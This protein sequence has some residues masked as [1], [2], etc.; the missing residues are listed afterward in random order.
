MRIKRREILTAI[1]A[2]SMPFAAVQGATTMYGLIVKVTANS[3]Q[4]DAL[5]SVLLAG[6]QEMPG[7]LSYVIAKDSADENAIWVTE[8]WDSK[9]S[10]DA[11]VSLPSVQEAIAKAKPLIA[12]FGQ[13]VITI[14]VG[15]RGL[16]QP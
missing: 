7:N 6:T 2:M 11:S 3:G 16:K 14:P 5:I 15:G 10:H 13:P 12:V 4:Q 1:A 9:T 8:I